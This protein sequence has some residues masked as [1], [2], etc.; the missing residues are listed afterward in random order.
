MALARP[1]KFG[2]G[3]RLIQDGGPT[4]GHNVSRI[5]I[6]YKKD[7]LFLPTYF[8]FFL[9]KI[10]PKTPTGTYLFCSLS[11][12]STRFEEL[13]VQLVLYRKYQPHI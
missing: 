4:L 12:I 1:Q 13:E 6:L 7:L 9:R 11:K 8:F 2:K 10:F 3:M 5:F